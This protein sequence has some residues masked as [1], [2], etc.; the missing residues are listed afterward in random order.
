MNTKI[1]SGINLASAIITITVFFLGFL[2]N[3]NYLFYALITFIIFLLSLLALVLYGIH[4]F[5]STH[6]EN[7][8]IVKSAFSTYISLD[9]KRISY[10][11]FLHIQCKKIWMEKYDWKYNWTGEDIPVIKSKIQKIDRLIDAKDQY[12]FATA[13]LKFSKPIL[14][15]ET[16]PVHFSSIMNDDRCVSK[17]H[18]LQRVTNPTDIVSFKAIL[19]YK[20]S[21]TNAI[22]ERKKINSTVDNEYELIDY[23]SFNAET[24]SYSTELVSPEIGYFYRLRWERYK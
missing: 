11:S 21:A 7:G 19:P 18:L 5:I 6:H 13:I 16:I 4:K 17:T 15:N 10:D 2:S 22:L 23:I 20:K 24:K 12:K 14:Y 9:G 8:H 3:E 1:V